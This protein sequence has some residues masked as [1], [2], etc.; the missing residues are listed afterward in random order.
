MILERMHNEGSIQKNVIGCA[1][2]DVRTRGDG[3]HRAGKSRNEAFIEL[4]GFTNLFA[5]CMSHCYCYYY[6][7]YDCIFI[8]DVLSKKYRRVVDFDSVDWW[9]VAGTKQRK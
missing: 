1:V 5:A 2:A 9:R 6:Y 8:D 7:Y 4:Q 3:G